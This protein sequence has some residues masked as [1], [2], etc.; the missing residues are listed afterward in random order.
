MYSST[1]SLASTDPL[2]ARDFYSLQTVRTGSVAHP[3]CYLVDIGFFFPS[4]VKRPEREANHSPPC[5]GEVKNK[6]NNTSAATLYANSPDMAN[7][8]G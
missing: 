6:W 4:G 7:L 2:V 5:S 3:D 1:R 8:T